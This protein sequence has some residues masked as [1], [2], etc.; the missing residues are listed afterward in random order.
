[1]DNDIFVVFV[2]Q[3]YVQDEGV[4]CPDLEIEQQVR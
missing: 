1:M 2:E 3:V 4:V